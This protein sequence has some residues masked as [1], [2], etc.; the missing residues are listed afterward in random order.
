RG[1][2]RRQVRIV[3]RAREHVGRTTSELGEPT[4][5][6][7]VGR[8]HA[9][10]LLVDEPQLHAHVLDQGRL[11]HLR[12]GEAGEAGSLDGDEHLRV[13]PA[14]VRE[15]AL[16]DL[17][18]AHAFTPIWTSRKRAGE[19]PCETCALWPGWPFPQLVRPCMC[20]SSGP[21]TRSSEPQ[22]TGVTP[23]YVASRSMRP[24]LPFLISQAI[25]VPNWK[26]SRL[27][28][29]DQLRFVWRE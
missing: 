20:H 17:G 3:G 12:R 7:P 22:K 13:V 21:A 1:C 5:V 26:L 19:A 10:A 11:V 8:R 27:S 4:V 18:R 23:V 24:S 25:C 9:G 16:G 28:S 29:I 2:E 6:R 14:G 15:R